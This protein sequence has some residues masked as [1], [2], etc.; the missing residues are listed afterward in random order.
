MTF[1]KQ[2]ISH[3]GLLSQ[4]QT[5]AE[6]FGCATSDLTLVEALQE[7]MSLLDKVYDY[8]EIVNISI[9]GQIQTAITGKT[10]ELENL[11]DTLEEMHGEL[12]CNDL[13]GYKYGD[14][15]DVYQALSD[16]I[17]NNTVLDFFNKDVMSITTEYDLILYGVD[18]TSLLEVNSDLAEVKG[19]LDLSLAKVNDELC[20]HYIGQY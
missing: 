11:M 18:D 2:E 4:S 12:T 19:L 10:S 1:S 17:R 9:D 7:S 3:Y 5:K 8:K 14:F 20:K 13:V 6:V 15:K 16:S